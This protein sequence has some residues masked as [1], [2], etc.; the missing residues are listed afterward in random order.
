M[1]A[2]IFKYAFLTSASVLK[3]MTFSLAVLH[4]FVPSLE[5]QSQ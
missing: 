3:T 5:D 1:A 4:H 2:K